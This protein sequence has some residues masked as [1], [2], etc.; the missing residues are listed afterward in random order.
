VA[1]ESSWVGS[2]VIIRLLAAGREVRTMVGSPTRAA[3]ARAVMDTGDVQSSVRVSFAATDRDH[4][5]G[6]LDRSAGCEFVDDRIH[7]QE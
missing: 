4:D 7:G 1:V 6:R 5:A 2:R 3:E